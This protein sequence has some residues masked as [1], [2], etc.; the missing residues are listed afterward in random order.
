MKKL[1][2]IIVSVVMV[3][4]LMVPVAVSATENASK[5]TGTPD[6]SWYNTTDTTFTLTTADQLMGFAKLLKG[7][8]TAD[9]A[10]VAVAFEGV[11]VK[12]GANMIINEDVTA[13][14]A[15][16]W[17]TTGS[18]FKGNFDGD[19]KTVTGIKAVA[20]EN[21]TN[22]YGIFSKTEGTVNIK[23]VTFDQLVITAI[24]AVETTTD[25]QTT[26]T[27]VGAGTTGVI[28]YANGAVNFE[29]VTVKGDI[30]GLQNV[31]GLIGGVGRVAV[32]VKNCTV[33]GTVAGYHKSNQAQVGGLLGNTYGELTVEGCTVKADITSKGGR[34]AGVCGF[35]NGTVSVK[36]T[37][38]EGDITADGSYNGAI[39][40]ILGQAVGASTIENCSYNGSINVTGE[41]VGGIVGWYH[42]AISVKNVSVVGDLIKGYRSVG[43]LMGQRKY[44]SNAKIIGC[45][46]VGSVTATASAIGGI[47]GRHEKYMTIDSCVVDLTAVK[48]TG[49]VAVGGVIGYS[50]VNADGL[51]T[52]SNS[53]VK[54]GSIS[55]G[56]VDATYSGIGGVIGTTGVTHVKLTNLVVDVTLSGLGTAAGTLVGTNFQTWGAVTAENIVVMGGM[57]LSGNT[58]VGML[59]GRSTPATTV[60]ECISIATVKVNGGA[61]VV[62]VANGTFSATDL[63]YDSDKASTT[64]NEGVTDIKG[65]D[66]TGANGAKNLP[67]LFDEDSRAD[68]TIT[69]TCP[70]PTKALKGCNVANLKMLAYQTKSEADSYDI[71]FVSFIDGTNYKEAG[72]IVKIGDKTATIPA[73]YVY[74]SINETLGDTTNTSKITK[75]GY[76]ENDGYFLAIVLQGVPAGVTEFTV[77]PYV[78]TNDNVTVYGVAGTVSV[79]A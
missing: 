45:S 70:M 7:D 78:I 34:T 16:I 56:A 69:D 36:N 47:V 17:D 55:E 60:T 4:S 8:S 75:Y 46:V 41:G 50:Y 40:G 66:L 12:L 68:W 33:E 26:T 28:G 10:V 2:A 22:N 6:I 37:T 74:S 63:Y 42:G 65:V 21:Y 20:P 31:G 23:N 19:G 5:Y 77:T 32:S 53:F 43:G 72:I 44:G 18:V 48:S 29:N 3:L 59:V 39:G 35:P 13:E 71:R 49:S 38:V 64:L 61:T 54:V 52:I 15:Y 67:A 1:L 51:T 57:E 14:T 27:Y 62:P 76:A 11:T 30:K 9:P 73:T 25:G 79:A 24:Q 58:N